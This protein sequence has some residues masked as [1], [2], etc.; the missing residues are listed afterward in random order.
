LK[1]I[2]FLFWLGA[3]DLA[4][5]RGAACAHQENQKRKEKEKKIYITQETIILPLK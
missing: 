3:G 5:L 1:K 2:I 4:E